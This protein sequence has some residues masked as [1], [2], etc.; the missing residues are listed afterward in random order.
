MGTKEEKDFERAMASTIAAGFKLNPP[1]FERLN[2]WTYILSH[3]ATALDC[4]I[5]AKVMPFEEGNF[6]NIRRQRAFFV[7]G[8]VA[9]GRCFVQ[10]GRGI[11]SLDAKSVFSKRPDLMKIHRRLIELRNTFA[12]HAD[13]SDIVRTTLAVRE[14]GKRLQIRTLIATTIPADEVPGYLETL[15]L[16]QNFADRKINRI[17]TRLER[18]MGKTIE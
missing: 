14:A 8:I 3:V 12:A 16:I 4:F 13:Q 9:Y 15:D 5:Y 11:P 18:D 17:V 6:G 7:A 1:G 2:Y 10:A